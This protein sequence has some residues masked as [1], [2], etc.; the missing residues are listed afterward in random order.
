MK[1]LVMLFAFAFIN[2]FFTASIFAQPGNMDWTQAT[3]SAGW[4]ARSGHTSVVFDNKIWVMGGQDVNL[5]KRNDVWYSTD[6]VNWTQATVN[7]GWSA[8]FLPTSVVF[9]N[10]MW[11]MGGQDLSG[12]RN[13]VWYSSD[14]A[15]WTRACASAGWTGRANH[16]SVVFNNKIWVIGGWGSS[17]R[18]DV[19][20]SSD[21][22]NWTC[23]TA[24]AG[25]SARNGHTSVVFDNK[26]WVICGLS[27]TVDRNDVWY[28][29][30]GINWTQATDS[31]G[32]SGSVRTGH[33]SVVCDNKMWVLGGEDISGLL[34][35]VWYSTDGINWTQATANAG[36]LGRDQH[37]S[38][39]FDNKMWVIGGFG[40]GG[41]GFKN[42]VWYS[43]AMITNLILPNGGE[44]LAGGSN[45]IIK[46]RTEGTGLAGYRL[47]LSR[48]SGSTYPDT[49]VHN[50]AP[51]ESTYNWLVPTL[52]INTCRVMV[53]ILDA[54][55]LVISQDASDANF[56]I[57]SD[58]P[59]IPILI[60][61]SDNSYIHDSL[62]RFWWYQ[63]TDTISGVDYYQLQYAMNSN[64]TGAVTVN[65][66]DTTYQVPNRLNDTTYY[67]RVKTQDRAGNQSSW[68][69]TRSFEVD[70]RIPNAPS[71]VSP[72]NGVWFTN[73]SV[74]FNWSQVSF[75]TKS[76]VRYILQVD[77]TTNFLTPRIDTT[78][79]VSD[80]L[81]LPQDR[82]CWRVRA[83]DLAGNQGTFSSRDS[84][85]IDYTA[86]SIPNLVSPTNGA[87]INNPSITFVWNRSSDNV[88]GVSRYTLQGAI[89]PGFLISL[90]T[91]ITDTTITIT[92]IDT[93]F[94]W[95][96][97][98][99]DRAGNQSNYSATRSFE[100]DT[101]IPNAPVLASPLSGIWLTNT[102][103]I[104]NWSQVTFDAKS[105]VRYILQ[106]DTLTTFTTPRIDT[107]SLVSDT[108]TL[109]QDRYCWRVK[110]YDLAGNQGT[111]SSHDSF[112]I[113]N[114]A[115]TVPNLVSPINGAVL[116]DSFVRF[117]WNR[118]TDNVSGIRNYRIQVA[119]DTNFTNPTDTVISDTSITLLLRGTKYWHVKAIDWAGNASNWSQRRQFTV[120]IE[121]INSGTIPAIFNLYQNMPNP[122][123][124]RTE[125]RYSIPRECNVSLS[126]YDISGKVV[127]TLV[128]ETMNAGVYSVSWNGNDNDGRKVGQGVYF[129]IL[130]TAGEK[131][132]KKMLMLR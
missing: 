55:S 103:V 78:S 23:A 64:F 132:Q 37:T 5:N 104:F 99:H 131:M 102:S 72:V 49:I 109:P 33:T 2:S 127:K 57:D 54:G 62:P 73:T 92:L 7:A 74:I 30:D 81:T 17:D 12:L 89:E 38:V 75:D 44:Y 28:S 29:S 119:N 86:P 125:I 123:N 56:T 46:W 48:N 79:L 95:R 121:E 50:V 18:R 58:L 116:A 40:Y 126:I 42:D 88:S 43:R 83:Y 71:L 108:L 106:V 129:Y 124:S 6:G 68:S 85:G 39:V 77:T 19:W 8:R 98:S 10:K 69:S 45:Q 3:A 100:L 67:W 63:A 128:N 24:N 111:F 35:D 11:V 21:G 61:P 1:K 47:L 84:F 110:A 4:S 80:T 25:W 9:D 31:A 32:W 114:T 26:M 107:T 93:T 41:N 87:M 90:D 112:G 52:N 66:Y 115:P 117:I 97:K 101:R 22:I 120:G 27:D 13:D 15:N 53:Q 16:T 94:Y 51:T 82:Y 36:W 76:A 20:Y 70:T 118:S 122:F 91:T 65:V 34:N 60:L 113:D 96:V 14:G 105:P 130:K 59:S